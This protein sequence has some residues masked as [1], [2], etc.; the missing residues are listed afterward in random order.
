MRGARKESLTLEDARHLLF[1]L[2]N[3][4]GEQADLNGDATGLSAELL[5]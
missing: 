2:T 4:P 5:A 3:D 1:D